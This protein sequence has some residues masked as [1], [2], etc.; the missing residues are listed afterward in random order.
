[1]TDD[2]RRQPS[3]LPGS[4]PRARGRAP[5]AERRGAV[6]G[7]GRGA[8]G[9]PGPD[10]PV[11]RG[12]RRRH[13]RPGL[14]VAVRAARQ[15]PGL[16][17]GDRRVGG[18][19]AGQPGRHHDR[20]HARRAAVP[21]P[22]V[23]VMRTRE[24][25]IHHADL[26][27]D[28]TAADWMPSSSFCFWNPAP[29]RS[30]TASRSSPTPPTSTAPG[31][32][33]PAVRQC[34][35]S[36]RLAWWMTGRGNGERTDQRRRPRAE[37]GARVSAPR[38]SH[39]G[40]ADRAELAGLTTNKVAVDEKMSTTATCSPASPPAAGRRRRRRLGDAD[41]ADRRGRADPRAH[42]PPALGPP[43][44]AGRCRRRHS[45]TTVADVPTP[46]PS[47]SRPASPSPSRCPGRHR[48]VGNSTPR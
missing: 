12:A 32:S 22:R 30:T 40:R 46:P 33:G 1:M 16:D 8:R 48:S 47:P 28:Y 31:S 21:G 17:D 3:L 10:V 39:G 43:P 35:A 13:L 27:L 38:T 45:A 20:A 44:R 23:G 5:D 14:G 36:G 9:S 7:A 24:V 41:A 29:A 15:V 34:Q 2:Q 26:A 19:A 37:D 6:R 18:G 11:Q 25:E 4:T 42:H